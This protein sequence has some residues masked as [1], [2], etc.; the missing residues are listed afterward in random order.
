MKNSKLLF[1]GFVNSLG[2]VIYVSLVVTIMSFGQKFS[3]HNG[4]LGPIGFLLL[5]VISATITGLLVF[6]RPVHFYLNG[7][8]SEAFKLLFYTIGFL[9]IE[10]LIIFV[11]LFL[12]K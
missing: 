10:T 3:G 7:L 4:F 1:Y 5:F 8:K 6:G 2:V 9:V 12:L 11:I